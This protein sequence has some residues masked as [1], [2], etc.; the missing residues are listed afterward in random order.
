VTKKSRDEILRSIRERPIEDFSRLWEKAR[1]YAARRGFGDESEDFASEFICRKLEGKS[2]YQSIEQYF[3]DYSEQLR[4][5]KRLLGSPSGYLSKHVRVSLD[6]PQRHEESNGPYLKDLIGSSEN[7]LERDDNRR[8]YQAV[9][10]T[11]EQLIFDM[12]FRDGF[13]M[14][15]IGGHFKVSESRVSQWVTEIE[16]KTKNLNEGIE[17]VQSLLRLVGSDETR[18]VARSIFINGVKK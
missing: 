12:F 4:A 2:R 3:I 14:K 16:R 1:N 15:E 10:N 17:V 8:F 5:H 9:L 11:K 13:T 18:K 6:Q 7:D